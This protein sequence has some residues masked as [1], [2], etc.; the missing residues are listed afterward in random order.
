ML[1]VTPTFIRRWP[2]S[3]TRICECGTVMPGGTTT[4]RPRKRCEEC[5][6]KL[7]RQKNKDWSDRHPE[8]WRDRR[9]NESPE[10]REQRL[11]SLRAYAAKNYKPQRILV[12]MN[13]T[14]QADISHRPLRTRFCEACA[15][16]RN[17]QSVNR[18]GEK[19]RARPGARAKAATK[20]RAWL[21]ALS[22]EERKAY[23]KRRNDKAR[24]K[25]REAEE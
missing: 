4:G 2:R 1:G 19:Q 10:A 15:T 25:R 23:M 5:K 16:E 21:A 11:E 14:C 7:H 20:T 13:G 18:Y 6:T 12:C 8:Y 24:D 22:P 3:T 17:R 9:A